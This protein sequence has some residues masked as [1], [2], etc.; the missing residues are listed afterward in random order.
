MEIKNFMKMFLMT[1]FFLYSFQSCSDIKNK[2]DDDELLNKEINNAKISNFDGFYFVG[3]NSGI[4]SIYWYD[5]NSGRSKLF[6]HDNDERVLDLLI[7]P[8]NSSAFFITKRKQ[9][10]K[11]SQPAIERG[12]LYRIDFEIKKVESITQLEEG[13]QVIPFWAD[14]DRFNLV[15]NSID[16]TIASYVNKNTQV[17]NRFGKLLSDNTEVFDL[18]KDGYPITKLPQLNY[19]SPNEFYSV[20]ERNDSILIRQMKSKKEINTNLV[21]KNILQI[22]W[23][24][25]KIYL[26]MLTALKIDEKTKLEKYQKLELIIFNIQSRQTAKIFD[27]TSTKRFVL[28][29]DFLIFDTGFGRDSKI[30]IIKIDSLTNYKTINL[31][32]GCGLRNI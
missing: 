31:N 8:N 26:I 28:I 16:K 22:E 12:K 1:I 19:K 3:I 21:N 6:W 29:G 7:S 15:V 27:E 23:A 20:V 30:E 24:E 11:S 10:L 4:P 25:N 32:G 14:N 9:R 13:I 5:F 2:N 18:T 17:Y